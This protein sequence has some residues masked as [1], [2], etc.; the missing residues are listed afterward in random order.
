VRPIR[1]KEKRLSPNSV[2][3]YTRWFL[4]L[5]Y[6]GKKKNGRVG[7]TRMDGWMEKESPRKKFINALPV[8]QFE[9]TMSQPTHSQ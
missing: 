8:V 6:D 9:M 7:I 2:Y 4:L 5:L 3:S 1:E